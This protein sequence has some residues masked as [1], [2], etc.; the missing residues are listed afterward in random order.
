MIKAL[1]M[2][3]KSFTNLLPGK[4]PSL[5]FG[6]SLCVAGSAPAQNLFVANGNDN[7]I[8]EFTPGGAGT[9]YATGLNNPH[10]LAFNSSDVLFDS[11]YNSGNIYQFNAPGGSP[12]IFASGLDQPD[13]MAF[14]SQG[15]LFVVSHGNGQIVE[16]TPAGAKST[17]ASGVSGA[18]RLAVDGAG[19]VFT[20]NGPGGDIFEYSPGGTRSTFAS[21][22][23]NVRGLVF[24]SAGD[25]FEADY[26]SGKIYEFAPNGT[27]TV[28]A[29]GLDHPFEL[30]FDNSGDLFVSIGDST[31]DGDSITELRAD[32]TQGTFASGLTPLGLAFE[33]APEPRTWA[34]L[35]L[36]ALA[37]IFRNNLRLND[38]I[39]S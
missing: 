19:D 36:G 31:S 38:T 2:L 1:P 15:D 24:N 14:D 11:D 6:V 12:A 23:T 30:A 10:G 29:S 37:F 39:K 8:L 9:T 32:G 25:L 35:A 26:D 33:P 7:N 18:V 28:F 13:G 16:I 17:F 22:L 5:L 27:P 3:K 34:L 4:M 20:G 21:G